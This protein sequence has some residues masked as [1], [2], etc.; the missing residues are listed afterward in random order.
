[1]SVSKSRQFRLYTTSPTAIKI[2][3][4]TKMATTMPAYKATSPDASSTGGGER[5]IRQSCH[6]LF[7]QFLIYK[8]SIQT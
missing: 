8:L 5:E 4:K 6:F 2:T 7:A 1:M 3:M